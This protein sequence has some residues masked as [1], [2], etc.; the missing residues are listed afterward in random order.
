MAAKKPKKNGPRPGAD[1]ALPP[2]QKIKKPDSPTTS[3]SRSRSPIKNSDSATTTEKIQSSESSSSSS[4]GDFFASD[5]DLKTIDTTSD[6]EASTNMDTNQTQT[7]S[8]ANPAK[9]T[10]PP[11]ILISS[12]DWFKA[13]PLIFQNQD[14]SSSD[15]TAKSASDG[16]INV[17]TTNP[18]LF[19]QIQNILLKNNIDFHTYSLAADRQL[20][21]VLRGIPTNLTI[22]QLQFELETMNFEVKMIRRFGTEHRPMPL[23]MVILTGVRAKDI[24]QLT[25]LFFLKISVEPF[26]KSG[27]SQ[28]HL[29]Q[30]FGHGSSN[31]GNSP[32]CVKC[33]GAHK[34]TE[35]S[36]T[37]EQTPTCANCGGPHTANYRGCPS[38][39][40]LVNSSKST[41]KPQEPTINLA[42]PLSPSKTFP[43]IVSQTC[44]PSQKVTQKMD[45]AS[46]TKGKPSLSSNTIVSLLTE[47]LSAIATTDDPKAIITTTIISFLKLLTINE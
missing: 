47:L 44:P 5:D 34:N 24:F 22:D 39:I 11:P 35:C 21:V 13:A 10:L 12:A 27:P 46:A 2:P 20:K 40:E 4:T 7:N 33:A 37:L 18:T 3:R 9:I 1:P 36:K 14:L 19:R 43:P 42:N 32:R 31:C 29:C 23:C 6:S 26:R 38:Y 28:C 8:D 30:R 15:V 41:P 45:Y 17:K 25:E 16:K